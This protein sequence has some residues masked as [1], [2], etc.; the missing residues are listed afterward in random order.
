MDCP[1]FFMWVAMLDPAAA[2]YEFVVDQ[3]VIY[4]GVQNIS[5]VCIEDGEPHTFQVF[6]ITEEGERVAGN[7]VD[8]TM[9]QMIAMGKNQPVPSLLPSPTS[10]PTPVP[11]YGCSF[12]HAVCMDTDRDG[13]VGM[14]DFS[15]F[16]RVFGLRNRDGEEV[17]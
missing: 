16:L 11:I 2:I 15:D 13:I 3:E 6:G 9:F 12:P 10:S 8:G 17:P 5:D 4:S 1:V 14:P 7:R